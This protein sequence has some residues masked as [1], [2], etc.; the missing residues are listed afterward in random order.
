MKKKLLSLALALV[1][2]L[3]LTVPAFAAETWTRDGI[4]VTATPDGTV[5]FTGSGELTAAHAE[6]G[7]SLFMDA[8]NGQVKTLNIS[9]GAN[10]TYDKKWLEDMTRTIECLILFKTDCVKPGKK[11]P[12]YKLYSGN[13]KMLFLLQLVYKII[14]IPVSNI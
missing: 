10:V 11:A 1:M 14:H 7:L 12:V 2:C 9:I 4:T 13:R 6:V 8:T 5:S 3:G